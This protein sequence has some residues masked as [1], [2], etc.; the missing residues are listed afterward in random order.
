MPAGATVC[1]SAYDLM[2]DS[3]TY[4]SPDTFDPTRHA[5]RFVDVSDKFPVWGYGSLACPGRL[6][7]ALVMKLVMAKLLQEYDLSLEKP[8]ARTR[9]YWETFTMPYQNTRMVLTERKR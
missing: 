3:E 6:H 2:H 8:G 9:W 4:A 1:V 5:G 7:A